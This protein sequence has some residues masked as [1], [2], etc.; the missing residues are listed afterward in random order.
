MLVK[1]NLLLIYIFIHFEACLPIRSKIIEPHKD[2][3]PQE[4][5]EV[6]AKDLRSFTPI[7]SNFREGSQNLLSL[8]YQVTSDTQFVYYEICDAHSEISHSSMQCVSQITSTL[9]AILPLIHQDVEIRVYA[10]IDENDEI[11]IKNPIHNEDTNLRTCGPPSKVTFSGIYDPK[12]QN[13]TTSLLLKRVELEEAAQDYH[14][15]LGQ[16]VDDALACEKTDA[17]RDEIL[18]SKKRVAKMLVDVPV[19]FFKTSII[20]SI[21]PQDVQTTIIQGSKK[22]IDNFSFVLSETCLKLEQNT[23][24]ILKT[25]KIIPKG[26]IQQLNPRYT[27][28]TLSNVFHDII[29]GSGPDRAALVHKPCLAEYKFSTRLAEINSRIDFIEQEIQRLQNELNQL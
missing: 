7:I 6:E 12:K 25:L 22:I 8:S 28:D 3:S 4:T 16:F 2:I 11:K 18:E 27:I 20:D 5:L 9:R 15:S 24:D 19:H 23:C 21:F 1:K 10:C 14:H 26:L 29:I 13:I 17:K